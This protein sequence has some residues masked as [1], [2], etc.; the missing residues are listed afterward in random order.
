MRCSP[1]GD[2]YLLLADYASYVAAQARV[3][4]L[5][6]QPRRWAESA[7]LNVAG[8]GMFSADRSI[9]EYAQGI[10]GVETVEV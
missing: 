10:W 7:I 5:F 3:D 9:R 8:M 4:A 1:G 2:P 6:A